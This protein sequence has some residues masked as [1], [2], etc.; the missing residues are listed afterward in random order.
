MVRYNSSRTCP[1]I[2]NP[3]A[4][5]PAQ[6]RRI[7]DIAQTAAGQ[8][9]HQL[10]LACKFH[11]IRT[12][13]CGYYEWFERVTLTVSPVR[14]TRDDKSAV[15]VRDVEP[16]CIRVGEQTY[17]HDVVLTAEE[18]LDEAAAI[19]LDSLDESDISAVLEREPEMLLLGTGWQAMLPP[20]DLMFALARKGIGLE[21][22]S[23]PAACRTFNILISEGRRPAAILK[24]TE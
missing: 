5:H 3:A 20:R 17:L 14:F 8:Y 23:T 15:T 16:G 2:D 18:V 10:W 21:V 13:F 19:D 22:M 12:A 7:V 9:H 6:Q 1:E 24:I 11:Q 4:R